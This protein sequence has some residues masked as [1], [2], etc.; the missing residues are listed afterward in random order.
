MM[1][2]KLSKR[3]AI[4]IFMVFVAY[5]CQKHNPGDVPA[6]EEEPDGR[7]VELALSR[8]TVYNPPDGRVSVTVRTQDGEP[9]HRLLILKNDAN[10][11]EW[12]QAQS[13][14]EY[15]FDYALGP[16]EHLVGFAFVALGR[17]DEVH[18]TKVLH[19]ERHHGLKPSSLSRVSRVTGRS[20]PGETFPNPNRTDSRFDVGCTDLGIVWTMGNGEFGIFFGDTDGKN[21]SPTPGGGGNGGHWRSNVLAFSDDN[22]LSDGLYIRGM[23]TKPDD[24]FVAN[25]I[26][27]SDH[28]TDG[29]GSFTTI[30]TAAIHANGMEYVHYMDVRMWGAAG[31]WTTNF[32][33]LYSSSDHGRNWQRRREVVFAG[34]SNFAMAAYAKKDGN[35]YMVGTPAGRFGAA[36]LARFAEEDILNP[37]DYEYLSDGV[38][39]VK[40]NER[41]AT[42]IFE[43]PVGEISLA[44][45]SHFDK[46]IVTYLNEHRAEIVMR[47][48]HQA[49]GPWSAEYTL[50]SGWDYPAL[51]GAYI[52]PLSNDSDQLYFLM[53]LWHPYNVFLMKATLAMED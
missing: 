3:L 25:T 36:Y 45:N 30:P 33:G 35:V 37:A 13:Q 39:W 6:E 41:D 47:Y 48:A 23:V 5:A 12:S 2:N 40:G 43:A 11:S 20:L 29:T 51:Y 9:F 14:S 52:H 28:I 50:A 42:P 4:G 8:D 44:Y 10:L 18:D 19:I 49:H 24:A 34:N 26:I 22:D 31:Q 32:S 27:P 38:H 53:S 16:D 15:Q 1:G 46:W 7:T 21:F 17:N